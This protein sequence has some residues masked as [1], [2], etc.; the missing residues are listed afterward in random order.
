MLISGSLCLLAKPNG[1]Y[2]THAGDNEYNG[3]LCPVHIVAIGPT[4][5]GD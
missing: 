5:A 2:S 1:D 4:I 3:S